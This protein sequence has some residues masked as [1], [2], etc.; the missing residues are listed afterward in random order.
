MFLSFLPVYPFSKM[1][2]LIETEKKNVSNTTRR[3]LY[4]Y[5]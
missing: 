1:E 4:L 5:G 2:L 3:R